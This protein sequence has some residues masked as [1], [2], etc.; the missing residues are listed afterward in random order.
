MLEK[1]ARKIYDRP[2]RKV[3]GERE[4]AMARVS[5]AMVMAAAAE[6]HAPALELLSGRVGLQLTGW[7]RPKD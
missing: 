7:M 3:L 5:Y 4:K 2:P 1:A 6:N